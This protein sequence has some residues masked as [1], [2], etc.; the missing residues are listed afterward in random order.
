MNSRAGDTFG[1]LGRLLHR[2]LEAG[3]RPSSKNAARKRLRSPRPRSTVPR[4]RS[5]VL[6]ATEWLEARTLLA[7]FSSAAPITINDNAPAA[8]YPSD[9]SVSGL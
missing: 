7:V 4:R 8:P 5:R 1:S 3:N 2:L 6:L 9:I